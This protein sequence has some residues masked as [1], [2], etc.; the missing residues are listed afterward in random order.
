[1]MH[2]GESTVLE[3]RREK[4]IQ[5]LQNRMNVVMAI[6]ILS[7]VLLL[8][9]AGATLLPGMTL[10]DAPA[11]KSVLVL[12]SNNR[13]VPGN[14]AVD[15]GL[16]S[17]LMRDVDR[18][19]RAYS[20]FLDHP[21]FS[22]E[23]YEELMVAYLHGKYA[24]SPPGAIVAVSDEALS[25]IVRHRAQLFPGVPVV[26]AA[27]ST[28]LLRSLHPIAADIV[29]VPND[30]DFSGTIVQALRW[31]PSARRLVIISGISAADRAREARL[32]AEV[33]AIVG[34]VVPEFW[35]GLP[36]AELKSRLGILGSDTVVFTPGFF[37]D[38]NGNQFNPHDSVA[39][40]A[41]ASSAPVYGSAETFIGTG[42]VGGRAP[43]F[44]GIGAQAG[45]IVKALLSGVAPGTMQLPSSTPKALHI[46]WNQ[47]KR[48]GINEK[49][50]P[51]DAVVH[52][53]QP[54]FWEAYR[55][56]AIIA[57]AI[58]LFQAALIAALYFERRRR[59][60]AEMT[61]QKLNTELAHASRLAVAGELTAAI[62]HEINQPLGAV[63]T[64]ADA[65]DLLLQSGTDR[66][67]DLLRIITRI[68]RDNMRASDVIRR[69]RTLLA[70][71]E[72]ER[73]PFDLGIALTDVAVTL[74]PEAERRRIT[75][76]ARSTATNLYIAGDQTQIQQVL[77]NLVL[78]AM[79][80][81]A[82]LPE[83]RRYVEV[84]VDRR[85]GNC[86]IA[87]KDHGEGIAPENF[88]KLFDS[89][90]STKA[91]GMGL[92]L[93]IARSIVEAHGGRIW[94]ESRELDGIAFFV[95]L[96][97]SVPEVAALPSAA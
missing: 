60:A 83:S 21:E 80:A 16:T 71:H 95:E 6:R 44:E 10:A 58:F 31:H 57:L 9:S 4:A 49:M 79:D 28:A 93:S 97:A 59:S 33:P 81:V 13:L 32:R 53:K 43:S 73:R 74:R 23:A 29:G 34:S 54:T 92:G 65:A 14:V 52:F 15:H 78:N 26:H 85:D 70:K 20:E 91:S 22:G 69:P 72:P 64:S 88:P 84:I 25:F 19:V 46:D 56:G 55:T 68:R 47:A 67:E 38:G 17:A 12:Y 48:W 2:W 35:S 96:P 94:A 45:E 18:P 11:T 40:I 50:I 76:D 62:A 82:N 61:A 75:L 37:Q 66:R 39:L 8:L 51:A 41:S 5:P 3:R 1:M 36:V 77:I 86:L 24:A 7:A 30:Y 87:V 63:Q 42:V 90:F 89:F 27:V